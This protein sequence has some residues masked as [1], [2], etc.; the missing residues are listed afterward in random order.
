[1]TTSPRILCGSRPDSFVTAS[2]MSTD[3]TT[4][5]LGR[6]ARRTNRQ[7]CS[8][9]RTDALTAA[10]R[11]WTRDVGLRSLEGRRGVL[12]GGPAVLGRPKVVVGRGHSGVGSD[13]P[14]GPVGVVLSGLEGRRPG[15]GFGAEV[16]LE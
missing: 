6:E 7:L 9:R 13:A 2:C 1:M 5:R 4:A 15:V 10:L 3:S 14:E 12:L 16:T 8:A 11:S